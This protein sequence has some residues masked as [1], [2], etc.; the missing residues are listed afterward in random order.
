MA[1]FLSPGVFIEEVQGKSGQIPVASTS[2][3]AM[4]GYSPRGPEGKAYS[5]GSLKEFFDRFG[6]YSSKSY[7]AYA[8]AAFF[9]NG[10]SQLVF[11]RAMHSDATYASGSFVGTWDVR[12]S[13]RGVWANDAAI[14]IS[15]NAS[16]YDRASA[17]YSRFDLK[18][19]LIDSAT[20]LLATSES[21]EA[22]ILD[23]DQ[24]PDYILKV[25]E[26]NSEDVVF[27]ANVGGIPAA[28]QPVAHNAMAVG[29]GDGS[30]TSFSA[31]LAV[32]APIGETT[33]KVKVN[34]TVVGIDDGNGNIV[35]VAG[36]PTV[37]GTINYTSGALSVVISPAPAAAAAITADALMAPDASV[38]ITLA[39]GADGSAVDSA[40]IVA[41]S[42]AATNSGIY[43]LNVFDI[44]M[45]LALPDFIGDV[46]T[47]VSLLAYA[48]SRA[49]ILCLLQPPKGSTAQSAV[50]YKRN[51]LA[52]SS[53][54]GA[55][56]W[57]WIKMPDPLN[58]NRAKI[59]PAVGHIAGRF[60]YTDQAENVGK[61]PAGITR[62]QLS[63]VMGLER[64]VPKSDRDIVYPAQVN[65]IR[66]DAEVGT[67]IWGNKTLQVIGDFTDVNV[68]RTF[69]FLEKSQKA[70]LVDIV[71]ENVGP[72]TFGLIKTRLDSFLENLFLQGV[73]GSGVPDKNQAYKVICDLTNNTSAVSQSK[74]IVIDEFVKP[75]LAAEFIHLRLQKVFDASQT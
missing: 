41:T 51:S 49:D 33:V 58:K 20:G 30:Q 43:A 25:L 17:S 32:A 53:S 10:G 52:S 6:G 29:T 11:V 19:E 21:Y 34:G 36:G 55:M 23:D 38:A 62:G 31:S 42:L 72:V 24:D 56:Y 3:F 35:D 65:P 71:F 4:A 27:V 70:G 14:T 37:S 5:H 57:P 73:I 9:G 68:R 7:N 22:L 59:V 13:G 28:L 54:Y 18:I 60:A 12:A 8:A 16:F 47:D 15:G 26:E 1:E 74:R 40:D 64:D 75:N 48:S 2:T 44:Q 45:S 67:A 66:S 46:A 63:L 39:G 61:A 50:N 69:I